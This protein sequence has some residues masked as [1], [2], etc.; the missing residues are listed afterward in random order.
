MGQLPRTCIGN[1]GEMTNHLALLLDKTSPSSL[2][3]LLL[4][5]PWGLL[6]GL[7]WGRLGLPWA[8]HGQFQTIPCHHHRASLSP[9]HTKAA[10]LRICNSERAKPPETG[11]TGEGRKCEK[12]PCRHQ[13]CEGVRRFA[14]STG[15]EIP[16]QC[17]ERAPAKQAA[18]QQPREKTT[19][20]QIST[21]R[22]MKD[23]HARAGGYSLKNCD[24][25]RAHVGI[26][27]SWK[28]VNYVEDPCWS[29][30]KM[31]G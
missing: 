11:E 14:P 26:G 10:P 25:Q 8:G 21:L 19:V 3:R 12:Q 27:L 20:E 9:L 1:Q 13:G 5:R 15:G 24:T 17:L 6:G 30:G 31:W 4:P 7:W 18:T 28:T 16:M 29:E 2:N 22:P 23:P